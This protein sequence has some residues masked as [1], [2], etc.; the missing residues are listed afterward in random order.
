M[1][2][3]RAYIKVK[4]FRIGYHLISLVRLLVSDSLEI[5]YHCAVSRLDRLLDLSVFNYI[6]HLNDAVR[7]SK[8]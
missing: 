6:I 8:V 5:D 3:Q 1:P 7:Q 2:F 4:G